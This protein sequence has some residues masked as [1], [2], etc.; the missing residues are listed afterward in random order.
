MEN[1]KENEQSRKNLLGLPMMGPGAA[2]A[3][4]AITFGKTVDEIASQLRDP[5]FFQLIQEALAQVDDASQWDDL[6]G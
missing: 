1:E 6:S 3:K 4:P 2:A 5:K